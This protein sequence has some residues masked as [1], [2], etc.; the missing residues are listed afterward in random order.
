MQYVKNKKEYLLDLQRN[1]YGF[2]AND[3]L[4][5][6][7]G[8]MGKPQ[9]LENIIKLAESLQ[10]DKKI[11]FI[12]VG[13]GTEEEKL[14]IMA[15]KLSNTFFYSYIPREEYE[16]FTGMC[17]IGLVSLHQDFTVPNF[18]SKTTD[19]CKLGL[20][21]FASLD[22]CS[23]ED[24]GK[25]LEEELEAGLVAEAGNIEQMKEKFIS[26]FNNPSKRIEWSKNALAY[27]DTQL[28]VENAYK[29]IID[30]I[31]KGK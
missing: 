25:F 18:P 13:K 3:F 5:I 21:I 17:D 9:K 26:M 16:E 24:Y 20:P 23:V 7:G 31:E 30:E 27:Y 28:K 6:F 2:G 11:K 10:D 29:T 19:Y 15:E 22:K 4:A 12:F 1:K 8:N 14:K